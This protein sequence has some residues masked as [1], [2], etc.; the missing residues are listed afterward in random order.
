[1]QAAAPS[2]CPSR[3]LGGRPTAH[4]AARPP[5]RPTKAKKRK[6]AEEESDNTNADGDAAPAEA[7][8]VWAEAVT[9]DLVRL[10]EG[11]WVED[12]KGDFRGDFKQDM[13]G[14]L[15]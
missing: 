3:P 14:D 8:T 7:A 1:M 2:G 10:G 11:V 15:L 4:C 6:T 9:R 5:P 12:T 13:E